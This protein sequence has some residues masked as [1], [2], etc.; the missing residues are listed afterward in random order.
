MLYETSRIAAKKE[1]TGKEI[2]HLCIELN[3]S[4]T[5]YVKNRKLTVKRT[6]SKVKDSWNKAG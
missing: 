1:S 4:Q 2:Q 6:I 5:K 3:K